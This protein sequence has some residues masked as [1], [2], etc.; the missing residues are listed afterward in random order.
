[1]KSSNSPLVTNTVM[2]QDFQSPAVSL[3]NIYGYAIQAVYTGTPTGTLKLQVS[4]DPVKLAND[5]QPQVPTNWVDLADSAFSITSAGIYV[6]NVEN[7]MYTFVRMAYID[8][9]GG[10]STAVLNANI[11]IKGV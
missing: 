7:T 1:M 11:N 8:A 3:V 9:S 6:W 10:T 4:V 5:V 2:N